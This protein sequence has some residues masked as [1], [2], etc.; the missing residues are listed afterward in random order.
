[1]DEAITKINL[2]DYDTKSVSNPPYIWYASVQCVIPAQAGTYCN[3]TSVA[4]SKWVPACAGMTH[5]NEQK[6]GGLRHKERV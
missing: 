5:Q 3:F 2:V 1:M 4:Y 6:I